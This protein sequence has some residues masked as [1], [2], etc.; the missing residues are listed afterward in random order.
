MCIIVWRSCLGCF[1]IRC[2]YFTFTNTPSSHQCWGRWSSSS[3]RNYGVCW[4]NYRITL[5]VWDGKHSHL[6]MNTLRL[7]RH[8]LV[9]NGQTP[10]FPFTTTY[11]SHLSWNTLEQRNIWNILEW[12]YAKF[13]Y[14]VFIHT[15]PLLFQTV[16]AAS[17]SSAHH[18]HGDGVWGSWS[19]AVLETKL[20]NIMGI[21]WKIHL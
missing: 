12:R 1:D 17:G 4:K 9:L 11:V 2:S 14:P 8:F 5:K 3:I 19:S 16:R 18:D 15:V 6:F 21:C 7:Q 10:Y 13:I 20:G